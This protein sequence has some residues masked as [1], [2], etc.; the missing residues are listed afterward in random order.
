MPD[1][2]VLELFSRTST[3]NVAK[4]FNLLPS[5][6]YAVFRDVVRRKAKA[7]GRP[8]ADVMDEIAAKR[9][10]A[11]ADGTIPKVV[12]STPNKPW[13]TQKPGD[14][15]PGWKHS[16]RAASSKTKKSKKSKGKAKQ[17]APPSRDAQA[18]AGCG[19]HVGGQKE[20]VIE[21][22]LETCSDEEIKS[23]CEINDELTAAAGA[24]EQQDARTDRRTRSQRFP[25]P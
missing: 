5:G 7:Q 17:P 23:F 3:A 2:E 1:A 8:Y 16:V 22:D 25:W 13:Y 11:V 10:A 4:Q 6:A 21:I 18:D 12:R 15:V 20:G 9:K 14:F 24:V 19:A